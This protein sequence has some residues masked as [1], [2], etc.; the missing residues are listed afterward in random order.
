MHGSYWSDL[1][2]HTGGAHMEEIWLVH[3]AVRAAVNVR[4]SGNRDRWPL[5]WFQEAFAGRLP[6]TNAL[7]IG[8]GTGSLERDLI[9][10][11]I[12]LRITGIDVAGPPLAKAQAD[13]VAAGMAEQISYVQADAA[14][15]LAQREGQLDA[16]FFHASLHHFDSPDD[17]LRKVVAALK[18]GGLFYADEYVGPSRHQ[19]NPLRLLLPNLAYYTLPRSVRRVQIIR[20]PINREDP[21]EAVASHEIVPAIGRRLK[22]LERKDYGGNLLSLVFPNLQRPGGTS[23]GTSPRKESADYSKAI[24]RLLGWEGVLLPRIKSY[25]SIVV[26]ERST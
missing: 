8:C 13:A 7:T 26:A 25:F 1:D 11:G 5:D 10:R 12:C 22:I 18:P 2:R 16:V 15:Y 20:A 17:I 21:T 3:P 24:Q 9:H 19:W 4:I 6:L 14:E 23:R